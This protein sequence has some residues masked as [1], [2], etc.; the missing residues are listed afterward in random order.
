MEAYEICAEQLGSGY[1]FAPHSL[2]LR[3][4]RLPSA[5]SDRTIHLRQI[6]WAILDSNDGS[7][8]LSSTAYLKSWYYT[9][10]EVLRYL[11][12]PW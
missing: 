5:A 11:V 1:A 2:S 10:R 12:E 8:K 7:A 4:S 3:S 9:K 6:P